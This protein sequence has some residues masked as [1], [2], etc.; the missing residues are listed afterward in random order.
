MSKRRGANVE[1]EGENSLRHR[2][3][4]DTCK[5]ERINYYFESTNE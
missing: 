2:I 1:N 5:Q 4:V 3:V